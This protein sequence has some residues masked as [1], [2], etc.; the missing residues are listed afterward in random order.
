MNQLSVILPA[1]NAEH[2]LQEAIASVQK[3][4]WNGKIEIIVVDDGSAD[5]TVSIAKS[6]ADTVIVNQHGGAAKARNA[7][8]RSATG[9]WIFLLDA[10]DVLA[11]NALETLY[12]PFAENKDIQAVFAK[13]QD[14][15]SPE[16]TEEQKAHLC[17]RE[18]SYGGVLPGCALL[19]RS[20]F[21]SVG[22]FDD[23]LS[24]GETIAWQMALRE[25]HI[26]TVS[27]DQVVLYRRLHMNNT[28]R[29]QQ[30]QE[31]KNYAAILRQ[32]LKNRK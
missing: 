5:Q 27:L 23:T 13:A 14:F 12:A 29:L 3:Q 7:G 31:M 10:D 21:D 25:K 4:T 6:I 19:R 17:L 20:V 15:L 32:K 28:G 24:S 9:D 2:F 30:Q 8:I 16:L 18:D 11:D 22:L 1:Y 26:Q